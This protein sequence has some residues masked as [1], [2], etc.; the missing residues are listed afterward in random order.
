[1][2]YTKKEALEDRIVRLLGLRNQTVPSLISQ[3]K[4]EGIAPT[5]QGVY[6]SLRFLLS[7]E[8]VIKNGEVFSLSEEWRNK[9]ITELGRTDN[10]FELSEKES[11]R[12]DLASLVHL[13]QQWKNIVLPL[14]EVY[15]NQPTFF[16][17]PHDIWVY[18]SQTRRDSEVAYYKTFEEKKMHAFLVTGGNTLFDRAIK[19]E[20]SGTY[21]Q[22]SVGDRLFRD[23]DYLTIFNDYIITVRVSPRLAREIIECYQHATTTDNLTKLLHTVGIEKKKVKLIIER[24]KEKAKKLRKKLSKDFFIPQELIKEFDL[25]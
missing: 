14:H 4:E 9:T 17:N 5:I 8:V 20:R 13:D 24:D 3:I 25:Y 12:L 1:M 18:L 19:K 22:I 7:E 15:P 16:Y 6:K 10:R 21:I 23:T 2:I 11:I